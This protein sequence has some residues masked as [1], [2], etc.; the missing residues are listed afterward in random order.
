M[1]LRRYVQE[2]CPRTYCYTTHFMERMLEV[3]ED[4]VVY[5]RKEVQNYSDYIDGGLFTLDQL[6]VPINIANTHWIFLR[7]DFN[8]KTLE[9][10]D[11]FGTANPSNRKYLWAMRRYLYDEKFKDVAP[12]QRPDFDQWKT[13][14]AIRDMSSSSPRQTNGDDCG[15]FTILSIYLLSRGV[16]LSR[17]TYSQSCVER[18][19]LRRSIAFALLQANECAPTSSVRHHLVLPQGRPLPEGIAR[20]RRAAITTASAQRKRRREGRTLTAGTEASEHAVRQPPQHRPR[21]DALTNRKRNAK[22][23][24]ANP[25][26]QLTIAQTLHRPKKRAR[27]RGKKIIICYL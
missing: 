21:Q 6:F 9:L 20:K 1:F 27:K 25:H 4:C 18:R 8:R 14:W 10:Y 23:L 17:S 22:S 26:S 19:Q 13:T 15:V 11:S 7:V 16:Q 5:N 24:T 2:T 3:E 12:G